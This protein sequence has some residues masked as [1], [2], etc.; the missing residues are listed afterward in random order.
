MCLVQNNWFLGYLD[1]MD[2]LQNALSKDKVIVI[3]YDQMNYH[4]KEISAS[5]LSLSIRVAMILSI[6]NL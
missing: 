2:S 4:D 5:Q 1:L 6:L 3:F